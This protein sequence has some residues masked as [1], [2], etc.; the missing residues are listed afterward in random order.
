LNSS[1]SAPLSLFRFF[2]ANSGAGGFRRHGIGGGACCRS[3]KAAIIENANWSGTDD[4]GRTLPTVE[5]TGPPR[6]NRWVGLFSTQWHK[7]LRHSP[8]VFNMAEFLKTRP[9]FMDFTAHPPGGPDF[10]EFCW[11]DPLFGYYRSADPWVIR[12]P[13]VMLVDA[14]VDYLI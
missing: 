14:G 11:A 9:G 13:L 12:K 5:E 2:P 1:W 4:L 8:G 3:T 6:T 10:P 7:N